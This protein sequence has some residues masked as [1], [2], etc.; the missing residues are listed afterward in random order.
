MGNLSGYKTGDTWGILMSL[1]HAL[2]YH[3]KGQ[4]LSFP[5]FL[6]IRLAQ[7]DGWRPLKSSVS[8]Q[9]QTRHEVV[10]LCY[11]KLRIQ[12]SNAFSDIDMKDLVRSW[13]GFV[14]AAIKYPSE[15][16]FL[17]LHLSSCST[18]EI[19]SF[20]ASVCKCLC[21]HISNM[22]QFICIKDTK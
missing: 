1:Q 9:V 15:P 10:L 18:P 11:V 3:R 22:G 13:N 8:L 5:G 21:W 16:Q 17:Y 19:T 14:E 6:S 7:V 20:M 12:D 4:N 2:L